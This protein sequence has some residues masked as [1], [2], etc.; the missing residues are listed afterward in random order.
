MASIFITRNVPALIK[1]SLVDEGHTLSEWTE[2]RDLTADELIRHAQR[3]DALFS[4]GANQINKSFLNACKHLRV[5]ALCSVGYDQVNVTEASKLGIPI[6]NT[7]GVLSKATADVAFL[8]M[9]NVAR[10]AIHKHKEILRG[11]WGFF[12][13]MADLGIELQGKTL[14]IFGLGRIGYEMAKS[15]RGAFDMRVIYHNRGR[16]EMAETELD[17]GSVSFEELLQQSDVLSVHANLNKETRGLFN[18]DAFSKMKA[19]AIFINTS[20]GSLHNES[21]LRQA[22]ERGTIWGAGLD[23]TDPEPMAPDNPLLQLPNVA[24]LPHIGS[25]TIET[26]MKMMQLTVENLIA[27]LA[28]KRLPYCVN[29]EVYEG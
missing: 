11:N 16:N 12:D 1:Q 26:R 3:C 18:R 29:P 21:D 20:R 8:L 2:K 15:C 27:G 4:V 28:G 19:S 17:A 9:Q 25:A 5:I 14:G 10:K 23:V 22:L 24:V 6:G 7:P 13:P